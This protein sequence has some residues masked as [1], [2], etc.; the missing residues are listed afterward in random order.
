MAALAA[1][2]VFAQTTVTLDGYI[3]RG[4]LHTSNSNGSSNYRGVSS[5]I[6]GT[7][8]LGVKVDEQINPDLNARVWISTDWGDIGGAQQDGAANTTNTAGTVQTVESGNA[9]SFANSQNYIQLESKT[10]GGIKFGTINAQTLTAVT[11]VGAPGFSTGVGSS[12]SSSFSVHDGFNTGTPGYGGLV[13]MSNT[14]GRISAG[15]RAIRMPNTFQ[16]QTPVIAGFQATLQIAAK[17]DNGAPGNTP[18]TLDGNNKLTAIRGTGTAVDTVGMKEGALR[19]TNGPLDLM[20]AKIQYVAADGAVTYGAGTNAQ[21]R[22]IRANNT[23]YAGNLA[24]LPTL[25]VYAAA[26]SS[27]MIASTEILSV[28][29]KFRQYGVSFDLTPVAS[30]W[31]QTAKVDDKTIADVDRKMTG[32]GA[33][34]MLSKRTRVYYRADRIIYNVENPDGIGNKQTRS[35][36]GLSHSF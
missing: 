31:A 15:A 36:I 22:G 25:K 21:E 24:V 13:N 35:A 3:D 12:F 1:T 30:I 17:N 5:S 2:S 7:T 19:Y 4:F 6:A 33:N 16:Y 28:D 23:T 9:G 34:Y 26:G 20:V 14:V 29:S 11:G 18:T 8:T 10:F 27:R 32:V